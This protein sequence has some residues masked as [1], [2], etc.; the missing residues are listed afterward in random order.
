VKPH[1]IA[2]AE[3]S[4]QPLRSALHRID[5]DAVEVDIASALDEPR[6]G[7]KQ[8]CVILDRAQIRNAQQPQRATGSA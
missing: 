3:L 5:A 4:G 6:N 8:R 1:D 7:V 2:D